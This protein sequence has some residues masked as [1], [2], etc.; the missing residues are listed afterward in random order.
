MVQVVAT[1]TAVVTVPT[2]TL[3]ITATA[4]NNNIRCQRRGQWTKACAVFVRNGHVWPQFCLGFIFSRC[5]R[6][7]LPNL[8][9]DLVGVREPTL[10]Q[11]VLW[12]FP[13]TFLT[14]SISVTVTLP[15]F[16]TPPTAQ[17]D[18]DLS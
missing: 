9:G 18:E 15:I 4:I 17:F 10:F 11:L 6:L 12:S 7:V 1:C 8:I 3:A 13:L 14:A 5:L 16:P 2:S